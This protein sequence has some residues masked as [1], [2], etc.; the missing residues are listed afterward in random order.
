MAIA[1]S[2]WSFRPDRTCVS[3]IFCTG[4]WILYNGISW[5][6]F[7]MIL[8]NLKTFC[9]TGALIIQKK[10]KSFQ[11]VAGDSPPTPQKK[12]KKK[13]SDSVRTSLVV[14]GLTVWISNWSGWG[15]RIPHATWCGQTNKK[16]QQLISSLTPHSKLKGAN[17]F[18]LLWI[19]EYR[20][21]AS[22]V[23]PWRRV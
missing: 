12:K 1:Y 13:K 11:W 19:T 3:C 6:A 4:R 18:L 9:I 8:P 5:E 16:V 22:F 7:S 17:H 21:K 2:R 20:L 10:K 23:L 15:T 14:Q